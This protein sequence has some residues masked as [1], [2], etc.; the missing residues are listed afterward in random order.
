[1]TTGSRV[2]KT[3]IC[4][5]LDDALG[6]HGWRRAIASDAGSKAAASAATECEKA[7]GGRIMGLS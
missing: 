4:V 6:A 2:I 3:P 5:F 7:W 1:V